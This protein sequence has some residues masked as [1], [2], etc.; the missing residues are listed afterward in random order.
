MSYNAAAP[1]DAALFSPEGI[2]LYQLGFNQQLVTNA[3]VPLY[4]ITYHSPGLYVAQPSYSHLQQTSQSPN[5]GIGQMR[6]PFVAQVIVDHQFYNCYCQQ[7][8]FYSTIK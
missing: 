2:P 6:W 3:N 4:P 7:L 1:Y 5:W 8:N